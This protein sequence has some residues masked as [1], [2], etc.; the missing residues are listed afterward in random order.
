MTE[1]VGGIFEVQIPL[2]LVMPSGTAVVSLN[3][4]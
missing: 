3:Y 1:S 2:N 4:D